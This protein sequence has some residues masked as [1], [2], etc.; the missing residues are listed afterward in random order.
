MSDNLILPTAF[1]QRM[2]SILRDESEAFFESL[3]AK[4]HVSVRINPCKWN[5]AV[6]LEKI[7]WSG[8]GFYPV[9]RPLFTLDPWFHAGAYYVQEPA[10]MFL[11]R[12]FSAIPADHG[13][14]LILDL[15]AAPGGKSTHILSLINE[16]DLL[17]ANEVIKSRASVLQE[18]ISKWGYSNVMVTQNDPRDFARL[19]GLF[20]IVVVDA[21]CSGEGLFRKGSAA[22]GEWSED[23]AKLCAARQRRI[24]DDAWE[25]LKPD[26]FL[27]YSTCTFNPEENEVNLSWLQKEKDAASIAIPME[28]QWS[29]TPVN[30]ESIAGYRFY[31]HKTRGEGFFLGV[32]QKTENASTVM[33]VKTQGKQVPFPERKG[34]A[35]Q[36][37]IAGAEKADFT[38]RGEVTYYLKNQHIAMLRFFEP[39]LNILQ[40][41]M[42]I[43]VEKAG[44]L[45]PH[46]A[47]AHNIRY[48]RAA[49]PD[50]PLDLKNALRF[51]R[52][53]NIAVSCAASDWATV[54]FEKIPLGWVKN[55]GVRV[56]NYFPKEWRIRMELREISTLWHDCEATD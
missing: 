24:L 46:P 56:N 5:K 29:I 13:P 45:N 23:N 18:N 47:L 36:K 12:A 27:I 21:P 4:P 37:W 1:R 48:N 16:T 53:E 49:F 22:V 14:R 10:S 38:E 40:A 2:V 50:V 30:F 43:A 19:Q 42:P 8:W 15:C 32:L 44:K 9:E 25:C 6:S 11:E 31:P 51:M 39:R 17:V 35:L 33:R 7:P 3:Q 55:I 34:A 52:R 20:D 54:S 28:A 26:G 41:G